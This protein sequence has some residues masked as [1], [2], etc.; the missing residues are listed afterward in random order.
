VEP[1]VTRR[2]VSATIVCLLDVIEY[3]IQRRHLHRM[4]YRA[5][6][7]S[8]VRLTVGSRPNLRDREGPVSIITY[9]RSAKAP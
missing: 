4:T 7:W 3:W 8:E 6:K 5:E 2:A 9:C 1:R